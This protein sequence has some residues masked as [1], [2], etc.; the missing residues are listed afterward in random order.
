MNQIKKERKTVT[1]RRV[2]DEES[3]KIFSRVEKPQEYFSEMHTFLLKKIF[4]HVANNPKL[5]VKKLSDLLIL[6]GIFL[7][8]N[9]IYK[10]LVKHNLNNHSLR[11]AWKNNRRKLK[12]PT[13]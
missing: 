5:G 11:K 13:L 6:D 3:T 2:T 1:R 7:S 9:T 8:H 10:M 12:E 4:A